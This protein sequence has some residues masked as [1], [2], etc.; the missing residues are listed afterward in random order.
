MLSGPILTTVRSGDY[1]SEPADSYW[2]KEW[3]TRPGGTFVIETF[4]N[5]VVRPTLNVR[6]K[7]GEMFVLLS[8]LR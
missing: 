7:P 2:P 1:A 6:G 8:A 5:V 4:Q 3:M